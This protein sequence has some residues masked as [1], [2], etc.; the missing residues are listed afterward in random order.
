MKLITILMDPN[1]AVLAHFMLK[2]RLR[3]LCMLGCAS[4]IVGSVVIVIHAPQERV[5]TSIQEIWNLATQPGY[6]HLSSTPI[7]F[8]LLS[9]ML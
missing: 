2:E 1:S 4:C 6:H 7:W 9:H 5:P 3:K 8:Q